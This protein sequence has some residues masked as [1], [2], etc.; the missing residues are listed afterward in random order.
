[1]QPPLNVDLKPPTLGSLVL[2]SQRF[3]GTRGVALSAQISDRGMLDA[4]YYRFN[5]KGRRVY[6]GYMTWRTYIGVNHLKLG[7]RSKHFRARPGRYEVVLRATDTANNVSKPI[8]K[9]FE[10]VS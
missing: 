9:R 6:N 7:A 1:P 3:K 8:K 5:S 2:K 10:I 4:E